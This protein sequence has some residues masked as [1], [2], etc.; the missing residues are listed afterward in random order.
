MT[1]IPTIKSLNAWCPKCKLVFSLTPK[2]RKLTCPMC[3]FVQELPIVFIN[4]DECHCMDC[5]TT[6]PKNS[7]GKTRCHQCGKTT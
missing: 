6:F 3:K 4:R 1:H 2:D 5:H 7:T